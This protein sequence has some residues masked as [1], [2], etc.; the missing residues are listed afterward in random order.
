MASLFDEYLSTGAVGLVYA[1]FLY[2]EMLIL[3]QLRQ[4]TIF[5]GFLDGV[6]CILK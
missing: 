4:D 3:N 1:S 5:S 6:D 2:W